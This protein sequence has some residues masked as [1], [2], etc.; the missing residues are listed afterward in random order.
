MQT[1][2]VSLPE[3]LKAFVDEQ[4]AQGGYSSASEYVRELLRAAQD[5]KRADRL[6]ELLSEGLDSGSA[7]PATPEFWDGVRADV[8][9]R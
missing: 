6:S 5:R 9:P 7:L 4:V 3:V 8:A 2:N 1:M